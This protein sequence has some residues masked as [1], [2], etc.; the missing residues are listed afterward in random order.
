MFGD[1]VRAHRGRLGITQEE[2]AD[3]SGVSVRGL[4][5]IEAGRISRPRPSTVRLLADAFGL[6]GAER[7]R[8]CAAAGP[9]PAPGTIGELT[10][11]PAPAQLPPDVTGFTGRTDQLRELDL[12]LD[13]GDEQPAAV[14]ITAIAGTAGVGKTALA[15]HWAHRARARF[16]DGQLYVNLRGYAA[17]PPLRPIEALA[18]FLHALAHRARSGLGPRAAVNAAHQRCRPRWPQAG[19]RRGC[20]P[21]RSPPRPAGEPV[22][23]AMGG[24]D[25]DGERPGARAR[26]GHPRSGERFAG[27]LVELTDRAPGERAQELPNVED[28][29]T[30][31]PSTSPVAPARSQSASPIHVPPASAECTSV[32]ALSLTLAAPGASPRSTPSSNSSRS[33]SPSASVAARIR[34]ASATKCSS[35]KLTAM[36]SGL[37]QDPT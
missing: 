22:G 13:Q 24:V 32:M 12:L 29:A 8:F 20:R 28:A 16:P 5:K 26:P 14:V 34:P 6:S 7:D 30:R 3:R 27:D 18:Q 9:E 11:R 17:T 21:G 4:G 2:L 37:R 1:M 31:W 36:V 35:S 25:V 23:L 19:G 33:N 10:R 15:V